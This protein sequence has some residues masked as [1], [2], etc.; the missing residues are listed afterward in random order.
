M[1]EDNFDI[2]AKG[3]FIK[4]YLYYPKRWQ[5]I[6]EL[7]NKTLGFNWFVCS[8]RRL[9]KSGY[10][11]ASIS[12]TVQF[13]CPFSGQ[14]FTASGL[15]A[16]E[17]TKQAQLLILSD[18]RN[19]K[20]LLSEGIDIGCDS[21][22]EVLSST[23]TAATN[24]HKIHEAASYAQKS[25]GL[26]GVVI[27][28]DCLETSLSKKEDNITIVGPTHFLCGE[29]TFLFRDGILQ[30]IKKE[31]CG[32]LCYMKRHNTCIREVLPDFPTSD[33]IDILLEKFSDDVV[34]SLLYED[35]EKYFEMKK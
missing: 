9:D 19:K 6:S 32:I 20:R 27:R 26:D 15:K 1:E 4:V 2:V 3:E 12:P 14:M 29:A 30:P 35:L 21:E 7:K 33:E 23:C 8:Q 16:G 5:K 18:P 24:P 13:Y 17:E 34:R 11:V 28:H 25:L 31:E 10:F 22:K